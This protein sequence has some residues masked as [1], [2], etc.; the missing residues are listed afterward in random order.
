MNN[1][2]KNYVLSLVWSIDGFYC[3]RF[4]HVW[5]ALYFTLQSY[6]HVFQKHSQFSTWKLDHTYL[7]C[8]NIVKT[9]FIR[10]FFKIAML[11]NRIANTVLYVSVPFM[12]YST[13]GLFIATTGGWFFKQ[14]FQWEYLFHE[15]LK[16]VSCLQVMSW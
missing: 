6:T 5:F 1:N 9:I 12:A 15:K 11:Y 13:T 8:E 3:S 14:V 10:L 2:K 16:T 7:L 4:V